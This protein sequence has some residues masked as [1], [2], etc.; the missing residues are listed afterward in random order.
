M[1]RRSM[2]SFQSLLRVSFLSGRPFTAGFVA[3]GNCAAIDPLPAVLEVA[4][5]LQQE[6]QSAVAIT[7]VAVGD[8]NWYRLYFLENGNFDKRSGL[9]Q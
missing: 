7:R 4:E 5:G 8:P 9:L 2:P 6:W 1:R 3:V